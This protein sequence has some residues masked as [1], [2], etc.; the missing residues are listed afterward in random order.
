MLERLKYAARYLTLEAWGYIAFLVTLV[1]L[2]AGSCLQPAYAGEV[3][4]YTTADG[5]V[6]FTDGFAR[7]PNHYKA[8]AVL[9]DRASLSTYARLTVST[10]TRP[11]TLR[12][13]RLRQE[14]STAAAQRRAALNARAQRTAAVALPIHATRE[15]RWVEN[16][17]GYSGKR[18]VAVD[19]L[20]DANGRVLSTG[21]SEIGLPRL[22]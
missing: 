10:S 7:V 16:V 6:S 18:Y 11:S 4:R 19:V 3:Y 13:A 1:A 20:R 14:N 12:T 2:A 15:M 5:V 22:P 8:G 9:Q 21:L 17:L